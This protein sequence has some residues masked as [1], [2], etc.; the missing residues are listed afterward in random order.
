MSRYFPFHSVHKGGNLPTWYPP[1]P[2][3]QGSAMSLTWETSGSCC[4]RSKNVE[5][6]STSC[7]SR[8][9]AEAR[10][11]LN[12]S[13]CISSIQY[14]NESMINCNACGCRTLRLLPHP[15]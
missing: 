4:T 5:S 11:N 3:S 15:V 10:S 7:S 13:T 1:S 2:T 6:R 12:P 14:R 8:A 9:R